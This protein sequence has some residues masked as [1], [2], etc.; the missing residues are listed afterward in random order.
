[1]KIRVYK[2]ASP[3]IIFILAYLSFTGNGWMTFLPLYWAYL[4]IPL[5]E[6][7]IKPDETNLE[8]AEEEMAKNDR[9]YDYLLYMIV[10]LLYASIIF[11]LFS[12]KENGLTTADFIGRTLT[13]GLLLGAFGINVGHELGHRVSKFERLL[14][15]LLLLPSMYMH[16][17][18]EHNRGHH[19]KVGTLQDPAT[20]RENEPVFSF[21]L[22]TIIHGYKNAWEIA[23][24]DRIKKGKKVLSLKNEMVVYT[25]IQIAYLTIIFLVF[26]WQVGLWYFIAA[27]GGILLLE[28][29]NYIEHY[30]LLR[31]EIEAGKF[32]RA[33]PYHSWNSSHVMGR[34]MLFELSRHSD[35]HYMASRKYQVLRHH[36]NSP[37]MPT[38]Y[39]GMMILSLI[40]PL[41][42]YVM[43]RQMKKYNFHD[44]AFE[45]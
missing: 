30:G 18:I 31:K 25:L 29:V 19:K 4:I 9:V 37:Q 44:N 38:G 42:F 12:L 32:E 14:A 35:H 34:L 26:G 1:M 21:Y 45:P 16:F 41:F 2:Y 24:Y 17:I 23:N 33:M 28:T 15:K 39:P 3:F 20:S 5:L 22:R 36:E 43:R 7:L 10:P 11:F 8:A 6:L 13:M 40:P 27:L